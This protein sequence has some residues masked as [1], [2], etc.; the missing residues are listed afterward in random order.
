MPSKIYECMIYPCDIEEPHP[1][2]V[3]EDGEYPTVR[4]GMVNK[5]CPGQITHNHKWT[6][7]SV[8][9]VYASYGNEYMLDHLI[10][11]EKPVALQTKFGQPV[12][13]EVVH[14]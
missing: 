3:I 5:V 9:A 1:A 6:V 4:Y 8:Q 14:V 2:H 13:A 7:S 11:A 12:K 10:I